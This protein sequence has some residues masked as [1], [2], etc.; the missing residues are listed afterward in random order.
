MKNLVRY[1]FCLLL[2]TLTACQKSATVDTESVSLT[3]RLATGHSTRGVVTDSPSDASA[4]T[5][6]EQAVDG[7][8]LYTVSVY[9][10]DEQKRIVASREGIAVDNQASEVVVEFDKN[11][12]LKRGIHTLMAVANN[13]DHTIG[14]ETY[15]SGITSAWASGSYDELMENRIA[16][17]ADFM[18]PKDVIQPLSLMKEF[19]IH[20]GS[21]VV[22]GELV[23][24]FARIRI[25]VKNNSGS[26][27]LKINDVSFSQNFAQ[28]NAYVFDDGS[29]RKYFGTTGAPDATS[30]NALLPFTAK[31]I[32][33]QQSAVVYDGYQL[34]SKAASD[35]EF[36]YTLDMTY[37][38]ASSTSDSFSR[39]SSTAISR[40][41]NLDVGT[42]SYYL[43]Y[44]TNRERYLSAGDRVVTTA[45]ISDFSS[46]AASNVWQISKSGNNYYIRNVD[47]GL[48]MQAPTNSSVA[49]G[50][51]QVA[52]TFTNGGSS[53]NRY[54]LLESGTYDV[55]VNNN[56]NVV[57]Q[58]SGD[59]RRFRFYKVKK[60]STT[61]TQ[62]INYNIPITLTSIDPV[63]QQSSRV[64]AIKRNDFI[65][66]LVTVSYNPESGK[67]DFRVEDWNSGGGEVEFN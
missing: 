43:I 37:E 39:E 11:Y 18:S 7:R 49:L 62:S 1:I 58:T 65:N 4:W 20:A 25:E 57:G 8:Y 12:G 61:T 51:N 24:T 59:S 26:L 52:Y 17:G 2:L 36:T 42:E 67:F 6:A 46:L 28:Q 34:E 40:V 23:R 29:D 47:S 56:N 22:E 38:N 35:G 63:S 44:N 64:E 54:I 10:V 66:V 19:E 31:T 13:A 55:G 30:T 41:N 21:N 9:I 50:K 33:K 16:S 53:N 5:Q 48:Y 60:T 15:Q 27:P 45:S 32:D 14:G 3:L